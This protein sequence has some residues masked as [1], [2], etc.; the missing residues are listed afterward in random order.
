F[1][2]MPI[3]LF[4]SLF[5]LIAYV[6]NIFGFY[7]SPKMESIIVKPYIYTMGVFAIFVT[8]MVAKKLT[9]SLNRDL[10]ANN[11][12]NSNSTLLAAISSFMIV[13]VSTND[14]G[15]SSAFMG[16]AGLLTG[17]IV[18]F[19]VPNI[20]KFFIKKDFSIKLPDEV[21][22]NISQAFIDVLPFAASIIF[23]WLFDLAIVEF[24]GNNFAVF[25]TQLF[26][27]IFTAT[28]GWLGMALVYGAVPLFS[29]VGVHGYSIVGPAVSAIW[30][31]NMVK[32][33]QF[34]QAGQ[35]ASLSFTEGVHFFVA[36]MGGSGATLM[37]TIMFAF[38]AKS[39]RNR[40][41][42]KTSLLPVVFGVN[43]P[44]LYGAPIVLNPVLFVPYVITPILNSFIFKFFV[45]V[46][47][48]NS[49]MYALPWTTP[50]PIGLIMG[51]GFAPLSFVLL[52]VL[53]VVDFMIYYPFFMVYDKEQLKIELENK[54]EL[55]ETENKLTTKD[56][57]K[58]VDSEKRVLVLCYG[59]G[60]SGQLANALNQGAKE[61]NIQLKADAGAWGTH[62]DKIDYY[63]LIIL[64]PRVSSHFDDLKKDAEKYGTKVVTT[65]GAQYITLTRNSEQALNYALNIIAGDE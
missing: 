62:Y 2:A 5:M 19:I 15:F 14:G 28:E 49:F 13:A 38:L 24:T 3:I 4:S 31:D 39:K 48:M 58:I 32:N 50:A 46:L 17:F 56:Y 27:P 9:E 36:G 6:P 35:Q 41:I 21:P 23:F 53:I 12:I 43:E 51:T 60:T 16:T 20:Y 57:E 40:A 8:G 34:M 22:P 44:I 29:F 45:D 37:V 65:E 52:G 10:P 63:N 26:Q 55:T 30:L 59:S 18:A 11:K 47:G 61:H 64:A 1:A 7:W 33:L 25:I 54:E 42:G